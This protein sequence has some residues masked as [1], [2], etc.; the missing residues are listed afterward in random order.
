MAR[1]PD[2]AS[3]RGQRADTMTTQTHQPIEATIRCK[4]FSAFPIDAYRVRVYGPDDVLVYDDIAGHYT[5]C[6]AI[7][8][9]RAVRRIIARV[10]AAQ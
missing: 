9:A 4:A 10:K 6:H 7:R 2:D 1:T 8:D 3:P 5:R